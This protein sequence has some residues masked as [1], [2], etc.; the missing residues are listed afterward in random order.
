MV[1]L[2]TDNDFIKHPVE[3]P[4]RREVEGLFSLG[5]TRL[6]G[7]IDVLITPLLIDVSKRIKVQIKAL[8]SAFT[9]VYGTIPCVIT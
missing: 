5:Q 7:Y 3:R 6:E 2:E 1:N 8:D 9:M 4:R